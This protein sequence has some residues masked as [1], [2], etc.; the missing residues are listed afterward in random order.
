MD[1]G[2][3]PGKKGHTIRPMIP[4]PSRIRII[5]AQPRLEE[6]GE[7]VASGLGLR[8]Q[9]GPDGGRPCGLCSPGTRHGLAEA[10]SAE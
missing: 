9:M 1:L 6:I 8:K 10:G 3:S 5:G 2:T 4:A 7:G